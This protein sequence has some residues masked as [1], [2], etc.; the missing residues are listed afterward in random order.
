VLRRGGFCI[1]QLGDCGGGVIASMS[2]QIAAQNVVKLF[3]RSDD[4]TA[5]F[6]IAEQ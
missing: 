5:S 2:M 1:H 6:T 4:G 3:E